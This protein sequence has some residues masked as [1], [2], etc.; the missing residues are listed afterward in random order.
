M[1]KVT[2]E[3]LQ[4]VV[5]ALDAYINI[6]PDPTI[7]GFCAWDPVAIKYRV[8]KDNVHDWPE[9]RE[10]Q[11]RALQKQEA[12]LLEGATRN[13]INPI[14]AIF[15]LKQPQHGYTDRV[16]H[17]LTT[18]GKALPAPLLGGLSVNVLPTGEQAPEERKHVPNEVHSNNGNN[19]AT[20]T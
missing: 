7:V 6:T 18:Q 20:P 17:D 3:E 4:E 1:S 19:Q 15:R 14:M 13:R 12:Y 11:K 8:N 10:L 9:C 16:D 5:D 2:S